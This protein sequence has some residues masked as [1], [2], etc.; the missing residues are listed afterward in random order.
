[1]RAYKAAVSLSARLGGNEKARQWLEGRE[2]VWEGLAAAFPGDRPVIWVHA[3]SLGEFEQG[4]PVMEALR[5]QYPGY[6]LLLTFFSPSGYNVRKNYDGADH[7][8]YLPLDTAA[9]AQRFLGL[10]NP[11][12]AI[13]IKYEFWY[14]YLAALHARAVPVLLISGIFR[15]GQVFFRWY[16]G[17]F[18]QLLRQMDHLFVQ[19]EISLHMLRDIGIGPEQASLAGDTRFDRVWA[20]RMQPQALPVIEKFLDSREV[21]VA[22]STWPD[23]E[24]M[25]AAWW[26][27][28]GRQRRQLILAP[29]ETEEGH[30]RAI[31]AAFPGAIRYSALAAGQAGPGDV[32]IIDNVGMLSA[33]YRYSHVSYV[34]GGFGK[35]GIHNLL[36]PATYGKPVVIGPVFHQFHEAVELVQIRGALVV[37]D[38]AT[39][40]ERM[41]ALED[42]YYYEQT[43]EIAGRYVEEHQGATGRIMLYIQE[44]RFL[45]RE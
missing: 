42:A 4:R 34:G 19:N 6:R 9:N 22:G 26:N 45:T 16:G 12:M 14:H 3:A 28:G 38:E 20:L 31:E 39:F 10:V 8:C 25:L 41:D 40:R 18:R 33:L 32:L 15:H 11:A 36:E 5:R 21:L 17:L 24:K 30:I 23:D 29:H 35:A 27:D 1:M 44:K 7:V 37:Q 43:A 13:F 2:N